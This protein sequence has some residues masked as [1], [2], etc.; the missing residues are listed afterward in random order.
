[1]QSVVLVLL[2][3]RMLDEQK[4]FEYDRMHEPDRPLVTGAISTGELRT[5]MTAV[6]VLV[7]ALN[8][9]V[10]VV[11]VLLVLLVLGYGLV[12]AA[13]QRR[14][15]GLGDAVLV[16]LFLAYPVQLLLSVY[17][18]ASLASTGDIRA[19]WR[20]VPL[21]LLFACVFL[22]FEFARKTRWDDQPGAR[23]YS[24]VLGPVGGAVVSLGLAVAAVGLGVALFRPWEAAGWRLVSAWL[25]YLTLALPAWGGWRFLV[26]RMPSGLLVPAMCFVAGLLTAMVA[27]AALR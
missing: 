24:A 23:L 1:V 8:A 6:A 21:L 20:A 11:C 4:D 3:M 12:L 7:V 15:A 2:F 10:T 14:W 16:E 9:T 17:V 13:L 25:P 5:A 27:Q 22:Q 26:R 18:Y 19:D